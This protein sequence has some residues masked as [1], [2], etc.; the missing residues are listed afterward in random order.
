MAHGSTDRR[1]A[2]HQDPGW[3]ERMKSRGIVRVSSWFKIP[4][5]VGEHQVCTSYNASLGWWG[6]L[7][8]FRIFLN[9]KSEWCAFCLS[10]GY[11]G[12]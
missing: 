6:R 5:Q 10:T 3:S 4:E 11:E 9:I 1:D 7:C 8:Y 2:V 12:L